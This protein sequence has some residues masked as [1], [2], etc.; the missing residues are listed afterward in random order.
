MPEYTEENAQ[1]AVAYAEK[2]IKNALASFLLF[3][4][5][6]KHGTYPAYY[7]HIHECRGK[8]SGAL[9]AVAELWEYTKPMP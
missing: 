5:T 9:T 1:Q 2:C 4:D 6:Y 3:K 7:A 8:L